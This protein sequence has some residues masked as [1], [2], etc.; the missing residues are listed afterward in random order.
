MG[1]VVCIPACHKTPVDPVVS[2]L[3]HMLGDETIVRMKVIHVPYSVTSY[4]AIQPFQMREDG[5]DISRDTVPGPFES[6][7][8]ALQQ[9]TATP[10]HHPPEII[11]GRSTVHTDDGDVLYPLDVRWSCI[12]YDRSNKEIGSIFLGF[13]G[14]PAWWGHARIG[15]LNGKLLILNRTLRS[16]FEDNFLKLF[17]ERL[18]FPPTPS[19]TPRS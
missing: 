16:W 13:P 14:V 1:T 9:V 15:I 11:E 8:R 5:L 17:D 4:A 12:L 6:L 3:R 7:S 19:P 18:A 10:A 2:E